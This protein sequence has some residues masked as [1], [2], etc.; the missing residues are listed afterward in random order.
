MKQTIKEQEQRITSQE[1][2]LWKL[3]D[4][5]NRD[6]AGGNPLPAFFPPRS[7]AARRCRRDAVSP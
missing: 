7:D 1:M 2:T 5:R 4:E 6:N 3:R